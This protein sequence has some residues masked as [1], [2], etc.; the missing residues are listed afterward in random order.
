MPVRTAVQRDGGLYLDTSDSLR[1][2]RERCPIAYNVISEWC[3]STTLN[4]FA[5]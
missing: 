1:R 3:S 5:T 4:M 2:P